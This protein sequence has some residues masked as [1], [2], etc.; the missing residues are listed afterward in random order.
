M[1]S[2]Q[3]I[4]L[5]LLVSLL[6][7]GAGT[8]SAAEDLGAVRGRMERRLSSVNALKDRKAVGESNQGLL[9]ARGT[10]GGADQQVVNDENADRRRVYAA[11]A[12]QTGA[13]AGE[14]GRK[15][16]AQLADLARP[17]HWV[18]SPGGEWRQK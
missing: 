11:L 18:Q 9:E 12:A 8:S 10:L 6:A 17:G 1:N 7:L 5:G 15:R 13:S 3:L 4:R 16:A 14:V 2:R